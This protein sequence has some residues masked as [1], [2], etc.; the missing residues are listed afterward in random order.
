M[1]RRTASQGFALITILLLLVV[2]MALVTAYFFLT[3]IETA[4]TASNANTTTGF[5][6]AE[7]GLN[8]RG[9]E[10]RSTFTG[11]DRP[12]GILLAKGTAC[13]TP[14]GYVPANT[15]DRFVCKDTS[16]NGRTVTSYV[17]QDP[18]NL[19][20]NDAARMITIQPPE[21]FA[22]LNAIEY[23][24]E[25]MADS[26]V[27]NDPEKR[28]EA[29][30][31]M[32][33]RSRL[34]PLFQ[35]AA[36]YN[37]DLEISPGAT[38]TLNGRVH[39]NGDLYLNA[40]DTLGITGQVTVSKNIGNTGGDLY[41][42]RKDNTTPNCSGTVRVDNA[43]DPSNI[44]SEPQIT[45]ST[46]KIPQSTLD[47]WNKQILSGYDTIVVPAVETFSPGGDGWN[48]ADLRIALDVRT[49]T[50][51]IIVPNAVLPGNSIMNATQDTAKTNALR[52][53]QSNTTSTSFAPVPSKPY[54]SVTTPT[55][56]VAEGSVSFRD[57]REG[58]IGGSSV[59]GGPPSQPITMLEIDLRGLLQCM[60]TQRATL[61]NG[62]LSTQRDITDTSQ[63]GLVVYLTVIG[64]RSLATTQ[65]SLYGV[66][67]RNGDQ[68]RTN[69][70]SDPAIVGLTIISDQAAYIQGDYNRDDRTGDVWRPASFLVDTLNILSETLDVTPGWDV[71]S[72]GRVIGSRLALPTKVNAALLAGTTTTGGQEGFG[73]QGGVYNGGLENYPR[74]HERWTNQALT[75]KGSFVSLFN[76]LRSRSE[77]PGTSIIYDAPIR[78][79]SYDVRF[80]NAANLPPLSPR[81]VYLRQERF[82][83]DFER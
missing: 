7:A 71:S 65:S 73:G 32:V 38:M 81:F 5:Y 76:P 4:T 39:V 23:R 50:P 35:F 36:F 80:N 8:I 21:E 77:W 72:S 53:C 56:R 59:L 12:E 61:F 60:R 26:M 27:P 57:T 82:A 55:N 62:T 31:G 74:L 22:G 34:V 30:L 68:L 1:N 79:W 2:L 33:F 67:V 70:A 3:G 14:A 28:P 78:T 54:T 42:R 63:G 17:V 37:K 43:I 52:A 83:R 24:Y 64:P 19:D 13:D 48:Q 16:L 51:S 46:A 41:R 9:E 25:V 49:G 44:A 75:Y 20:P 11:Y 15:D 29:Q 45:C 10:I 47:T 66:R 6:A 40:N 69:T 58:R 18:R